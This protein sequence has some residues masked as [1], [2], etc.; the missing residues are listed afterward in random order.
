MQKSPSNQHCSPV[1]QVLPI[2]EIDAADDTYAT[3]PDWIVNQ[4]LRRSI[5]VVGVTTPILV[6]KPAGQPFRVVC[7]FQRLRLASAAETTTIACLV[8]EQQ[9]ARHLFDLALFDNLGARQLSDLEKARAVTKLRYELDVPEEEIISSYLPALSIRPDRFHFQRCLATA[10]LPSV[11]QKKLSSVPMEMGLQLA[12]W[13]R[14]EQEFFLGT[15][16]HYRPSHSNM[17]RFFTLLDELRAQ[18]HPRGRARSIAEIWSQSG[19]QALHEKSREGNTSVFHAIL[20]ALHCSRYPKFSEMISRYENNLRALN[21]PQ[22][23]R[24]SAPPFFEG[25]HLSFQFS[26]KSP[27]QLAKVSEQLG[28]AASTT[29]MSKLFDLL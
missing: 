5:E 16:G 19:C 17:K 25:E 22:K 10:R 13:G 6:Q 12:R 2:R 3:A 15:I 27:R 23:V 8:T 14:E 28:A 11:I 20:E 26:V 18:P 21:I 9:D 4:A 7:G 1:F 29:E 24:V